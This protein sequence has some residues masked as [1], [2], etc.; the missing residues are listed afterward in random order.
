MNWWYKEVS[1]FCLNLALATIVTYIFKQPTP[2]YLLLGFSLSG[3]FIFIS[4]I[5]AT[6]GG[7]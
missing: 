6:K 3:M 1:K 4:W 7:D 5:I 2:I